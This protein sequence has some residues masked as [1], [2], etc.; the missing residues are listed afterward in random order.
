MEIIVFAMYNETKTI[1]SRVEM[2]KESRLEPKTL[3]AKRRLAKTAA[4]L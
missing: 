1:E 2:L 3:P 4:Q